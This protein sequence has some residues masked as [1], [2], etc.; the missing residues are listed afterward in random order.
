ML[1]NC[2]GNASPHTGPAEARAV[3][4]T[5]GGAERRIWLATAVQV[6]GAEETAG[7]GDYLST[8][9]GS[10]L[11]IAFFDVD[12]VLVPRKLLGNP[13]RGDPGFGDVAWVLDF[14]AEDGIAL[15]VGDFSSFD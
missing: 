10:A 13:I 14:E 5:W 2:E 15:N 3:H 11:E 6:V 8:L 12:L 9:G 4:S 1:T 7:A